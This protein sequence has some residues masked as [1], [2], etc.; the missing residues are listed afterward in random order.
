MLKIFKIQGNSLY[1]YLKDGQRVLCTNIFKLSKLKNDD[2]VIFSKTGYG[3]MIKQIK[4]IN[5]DSCFVQGT[6]DFSIDSRDFGEIQLD[7]I[8]YKLLFK[9]P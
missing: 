9:L 1:P 7:E 8:Q 5:H 3:V 4:T 6:D 2:I